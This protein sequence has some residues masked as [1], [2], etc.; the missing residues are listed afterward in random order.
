MNKSELLNA[1][2]LE[3]QQNL[4]PFWTEH[5]LDRM[6]GGFF[7]ALTWDLEVR[8]DIRRRSTLCSQ[9]LWVFTTAFKVL[10]DPAYLEAASVAYRGLHE[11]FWDREHHGLFWTTN[12]LGEPI[13]DRKQ[14]LAQ[15]EAIAGLAAYAQ[16]GADSTCLELASE[17]R[18]LVDLHLFD[19]DFNGY[20]DGV[21]RDWAPLDAECNQDHTLGERKALSTH[22][23]LLNAYTLLLQAENSANPQAAQ[24]TRPALQR[25][26]T[27]ITKTFFD[28]EQ[29]SCRPLLDRDG[30]PLAEYQSFGHNLQAARLLLA[31]ANALEAAPQSAQEISL[32]LVQRVAQRAVTA[33]GS[34]I[35]TAGEGGALN[36]DRLSWVQAEGVAGFL[37]AYR[38][39]GHPADLKRATGCWEYIQQYVVDRLA[40]EWHREL[41]Q[42]GQPY[43][44]PFKCGPQASP[45]H[46]AR[47]LLEALLEHH[48]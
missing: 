12:S 9:G 40:G 41:D 19:I 11:Y 28:P 21:C 27:L 18:R 32:R 43:P 34:L 8:D 38:L 16:A 42:G 45:Y 3:L 6:H 22:L 33:N 4:L 30:Q 1:I 20:F 23:R 7:G 36:Q 39:G 47:P 44:Q 5:A 31:A 26:Y 35:T 46:S 17:L 15:A 10:G 24:A 13:N 29:G 25:L 37:T 2:Q 14:T 48:G